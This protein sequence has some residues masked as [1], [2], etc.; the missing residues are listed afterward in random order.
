MKKALFYF[1]LVIAGFKINAQ[2]NVAVNIVIPPPF[3]PFLSDYTTFGGKNVITLTNT[4]G[5][6][7]NIKLVGSITGEDNGL[8]LVT[9]PNYQPAAPIVLGPYQTYS[10][11]ASSPSRDFLT[12]ANTESNVSPQQR[13]AILASGVLPEGSY[14]VCVRAVDYYTNEPFSEQDPVGCTYVFIKFPA[15]PILL[16][17]FCNSEVQNPYPSF[18]WSP[19]ISSGSFILYDLYILKLLPTQIPEDAMWLAVASNAGNPVKISNIQAPVYQYKP[20]DLPLTPGETYAW[21]VVARDAANQIVLANQGR[22]EVCT[23]TFQPPATNSGIPETVNP[24]SGAGTLPAF[25]LNNTSVSGKILYRFKSNENFGDP[26]QPAYNP[27]ITVY[28]EPRN[29]MEL[30]AMQGSV[31]PGNSVNPNNNNLSFNNPVFTAGFKNLN[32]Q[33]QSVY[34]AKIQIDPAKKYLYENTLSLASAEPL[35]R[36]SVSLYLEYVAVKRVENGGASYFQV[37]PATDAVFNKTGIGQHSGFMDPQLQFASQTVSNGNTSEAPPRYTGSE[38]LAT[39]ITDND[40]NFIFNF[41]LTENTGLLSKGP[42]TL[43]YHTLIEPP[44]KEQKEFVHP[45]DMVSNPVEVITNPIN[46][47]VNQFIE[48]V[49]GQ[50]VGSFGNTQLQGNVGWG[51]QSTIV[52]TGVNTINNLN[53]NNLNFRD[54]KK[55][56]GPDVDEYYYIN[57]SNFLKWH[58]YTVYYLFKV[59]RIRVNDPYYCHPDV[60]IFAQPGDQL[61]V[62][63]VATFINS[64][65]LQLKVLADG[66]ES[67]DPYLAPGQPLSNF[68]VRVGRLRSFWDNKPHNF[69]LHEGMDVQPEQNFYISSNTPY[70]LSW[71]R[72]QNKPGQLKFTSQGVTSSSGLVTFKNLVRNKQSISSDAHYFEVMYPLTSIYNYEGSWGSHRL[73]TNQFYSDYSGVVKVPHSYNFKPE[74][75][76]E[77]VKLQPLEP[78]LLLRTVVRSNTE[79]APL[80]GVTVYLQEYNK[81]G[82]S[83][84]YKGFRSANTDANGYQRFTNLSMSFN[85]AGGLNNPYRRISLY[86]NGYKVQYKPTDVSNAGNNTANYYQPVKKG[87]RLDLNEIE[88]VGGADVYGFVKDEFDNP[89]TALIKIG[90][91]PYYITNNTIGAASGNNGPVYSNG[92]APPGTDQL[93]YSDLFSLVNSGVLQGGISNSNQIQNEFKFVNTNNVGNIDLVKSGATNLELRM[94]SK[95]QIN[96]ASTGNNTRVIVIPM[97]DQYFADTFYVNI[98]QTNQ[99]VNIGTFQVFERAHRVSIK[100]NRISQPASGAIVEVGEVAGLTNSRGYCNL[101]FITPDSYFRIFIKDGERVPIEEYRHIPISKKYRVL[102]YN[103]QQGKKLTGVVVD[104]VTQQPIEGARVFAQTGVTEYGQTIVQ[105]ITDQNGAFELKGI[106]LNCNSVQAVK[107]G[108][109]PSYIGRT[110][111]YPNKL[112]SINDP[113]AVLNIQLQPLK[114]INVAKLYGFEVELNSVQQVGEEYIGSGAFVRIPESGNFSVYNPDARIR[115]NNIRFKKGE[116]RDA[117]NVA[118]AEA[119]DEEA[120]TMELILRMRLFN[121][122]ITD[123]TSD[124]N[125]GLASFITV[126]KETGGQGALRG[127]ILTDLE[128]FRFSFNYAGRFYISSNKENLSMKPLRSRNETPYVH[129]SYFVMDKGNGNDAKDIQFKI[130]NFTAKADRNTSKID[131]HKVRLETKLYPQLQLAGQVEVDAGFIDV[132]PTTIQINNSGKQISFNL[133]SWKINSTNGWNYSIPHGGI[134][135][136]KA[137]ITTQLVDIPVNNLILRPNQ[138]I[139]PGDNIDLSNL[140]LGGGVSKLYQYSNTTALMNFDPA[141]SHDLGPHWRFTLYRNPGTLPACYLQ[142]LPGFANNDKIDIGSFTIYSNNS[143]LIQPINQT[144]R[145]YN[146]VDL[147]IQNIINGKDAVEIAGMLM[148]GIPGVTPP[149]VIMEYTKPNAT[150]LRKTK[151]IDLILET[152]GKIYFNGDVGSENYVLQQDYFEANGSLAFEN[153]NLH[154]GKLILLKGKLVKTPTSTTLSIPKLQN[155]NSPQAFQYIAMSGGSGKL[156][157]L[158]GEQRVVGNQWNTMKYT[159]D[160]ITPDTKD[161][162]ENRTLD[163]LVSGAVEVDASSGN[164]VKIDKIET[165][166]GGMTM[167]FDWEKASFLGTLTFNIPIQMGMIELSSG[168]FEVMF[169]GKGFYFDMLGEVALP[170]LKDVLSVN[171]GFLTGYYPELP[172]TVIDRHKEIMFLLGV[173]QYIIKDGIKGVYINANAAPEFANWSVSVPVPLF[174]VGFGVNAG[175]DFSFLLNFGSSASVLAIDAAAYAKA[176]AG[177]QV[178]ACTFCVGAMAQFMVNGTFQFAPQAKAVFDACASFTVFGEFCGVEA[179]KTIGA[180]VKATS[181][182]GMDIDVQWSA[183]GSGGQANKRDTSCDF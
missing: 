112:T 147:K 96:A 169:S 136:P 140:T 149:S 46:D 180:R 89:V 7:Y 174:S 92:E 11:T 178:L 53:N 113:S 157:V 137:K 88:M 3:T 183:C 9:K 40:G 58:D 39:A 26:G 75:L 159:A 138:L 126:E 105:A 81:N 160:L 162:L 31:V 139:M 32:S 171:V 78:E 65:D 55:G 156:K 163:Y 133:E 161:G 28:D 101:R 173:P 38:L 167:V 10:V 34:D 37:V 70:F 49:N 13:N 20:Y 177:V 151:A 42:V 73:F 19:V 181:G 150:V 45:L 15:P 95:F 14:K 27:T 109:S 164:S 43:K 71:N 120:R 114:D 72:N 22:S 165:P 100:V 35:R 47:V 142:G 59:L 1:L 110:L 103:V 76:K 168:M 134:V 2:N 108:G 152:P 56:A 144:K 17:P 122:F 29:I 107:S 57:E 67:E 80:S 148:T 61:S 5:N 99:A 125:E 98:P 146:I 182:N 94:F 6:T 170:G 127:R 79:T 8:F 90:D 123:L 66:K 77:E 104:A 12:E 118:V 48:V 36:T 115:F 82:E 33:V 25:A 23:F 87:Q 111:T 172:S 128:S 116:L 44:I 18:N 97:S 143:T 141:C 86:K 121:T 16:N 91:G 54:Q 62:P 30:N 51:N 130:H 84:T 50:S 175:V 117:N 106:P 69:P 179:S 158:Q 68:N 85:P 154:D 63:P 52:G 124:R 155:N 176:W 24:V 4:T 166:L 41:D 83:F 21:C 135:I 93:S 74:L 102:E 64:F 132:T 129:T 131:N 60:L 119:V 153:D 145:Y